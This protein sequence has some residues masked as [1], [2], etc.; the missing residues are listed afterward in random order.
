MRYI[1]LIVLFACVPLQ[2]TTY[3]LDNEATGNDD[4]L[5]ELNAFPTIAI[6]QA[7]MNALANNGSGHTV[8]VNEGDGTTYGEYLEVGKI[9][10]SYLTYEANSVEE[11]IFT[12]VRTLFSRPEGGT[13]IY[14]RFE[15]LH[16]VPTGN[17]AGF[18][19]YF[20]NHV[21]I[22]DCNII[23]NGY[24]YPYW[25]TGQSELTKA[26]RFREST[27]ILI[28]GCH[29][30]GAG[31][32]LVEAYAPTP[33]TPEFTASVDPND[34]GQG[35]VWGIWAE[36]YMS[37]LTITD[38]HIEQCDVGMFLKNS[39]NSTISGN[40]IHHGTAD[41][42]ALQRC[43]NLA[44]QETVIHNNHVHDMHSFV[45][46]AVNI[47]SH[48]DGIQ[49]FGTDSG[50]W[51]DYSNMV[52]TS[53]NL[54]GIDYQALFIYVG[55]E[56]ENLRIENNLIYN[57][58]PTGSTSTSV[59]HQILGWNSNV[60]YRGNTIIGDIFF[61]K[62]HVQEGSLP[63]VFTELTGNI[64]L[65][66][67]IYTD[68]PPGPPVG[69]IIE[70]E[71]YNIISFIGGNSN[72]TFIPDASDE[73]YDDPLDNPGANFTGL[74]ENYATNDYN[75][76]SDSNAIDFS[77]T[78]YSPA[79]DILGRQ[80]DGSPDS[81][82][83]EDPNEFSVEPNNPAPNPPTWASV[84]V[85]DGNNAITMQATIS[86][87]PN[88]PIEYFF[89]ET[90]G[91]P[92]GSDSGWILGDSNYTDTGLDGNTTYTYRIQ[93]RNVLGVTSEWSEPNS[94][95]AT[96]VIAPTPNPATFASNPAGS[97]SSSVVMTATTGIE[98][99][100]TVEYYFKETSGN[101]GGADS[102][103]TTN[104]VYTDTGLTK[105]TTYTYTVQMR[106]SVPNTGT[107]STGKSATTFAQASG[108]RVGYRAR[109]G[110]E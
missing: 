6:A 110:Y 100:S 104:P 94:A 62:G 29:I 73:F 3:Y 37:D 98:D 5:S 12:N 91:N 87:D 45:A 72:T 86:T 84:P 78:T 54:H 66:I 9:R 34:Y 19:F 74:F 47:G 31:D 22:V 48:N 23:G 75:L 14:L 30:Y 18:N 76:A 46:G 53:N 43:V 15:G 109:Y 61:D 69:T 1:W 21:Q 51:Q 96:D 52:V 105:N 17:T 101:P 58:P 40:Y 108:Y 50:V 106:D 102:G 7:V 59:S 97:S 107:V 56:S 92:G 71:G 65:S 67:D 26:I 2:A 35:F 39:T 27:D 42:I 70:F 28:D 8:I 95:L 49:F 57:T 60:V 93:Y 79:T 38:N 41:G 32:N 13:N 33:V 85:A 81:G 99:G 83:Y 11:P 36:K 77:V 55:N 80:R 44:G 10:T 24:T 63:T 88:V 25:N 68:S 16:I 20:V 64:F 82:A 103:W 89:Q 90:T 4:G